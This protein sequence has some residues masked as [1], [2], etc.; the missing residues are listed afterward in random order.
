MRSCTFLS[1][2]SSFQ[3]RPLQVASPIATEL[4]LLT[5][6]LYLHHRWGKLTH[7]RWSVFSSY[8]IST[9]CMQL[10]KR[11]F[12]ASPRVFRPLPWV[13]QRNRIPACQQAKSRVGI[14]T[15]SYRYLNG[16]RSQ[17]RKWELHELRQSTDTSTGN[18]TAT[19][20]SPRRNP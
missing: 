4:Q 1:F 17:L 8:V 19:G 15:F 13:V 2:D 18:L 12:S 9:A 14:W 11:H 10:S 5:R 16:C 20:R 3:F 6:F 7:S